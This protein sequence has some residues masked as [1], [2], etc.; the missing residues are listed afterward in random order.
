MAT[1]NQTGVETCMRQLYGDPVVSAGYPHWLYRST[2]VGVTIMAQTQLNPIHIIV[3]RA[4]A[5]HD[6][7]LPIGD[8]QTER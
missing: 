6:E 1:N 4:G 5:I 8:K 2:N 7:R 3:T